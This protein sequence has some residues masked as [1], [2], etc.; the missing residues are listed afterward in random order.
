[1]QG[2]TNT[3]YRYGAYIPFYVLQNMQ[4]D[5]KSLLATLSSVGLRTLL[6]YGFVPGVL[7]SWAFTGAV[8]RLTSFALSSLSTTTEKKELR[9]AKEN[10]RAFISQCLGFAKTNQFAK[11]VLPLKSYVE[12]LKGRMPVVFSTDNTIAVLRRVAAMVSALITFP[13]LVLTNHCIHK[14]QY[15]WEAI[16]SFSL[17]NSSAGL[18]YHL[19]FVAIVSLFSS[20]SE[21]FLRKSFLES[22]KGEA[23]LI[24]KSS[25]IAFW[26][27]KLRM[28]AYPLAVLSTRSQVGK[29]LLWNKEWSLSR[30]IF[31]YTFFVSSAFVL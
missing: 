28:L 31:V 11:W 12:S 27:P 26:L 24:V 21:Y 3:I 10:A 29:S 19:A 22:T 7:Y 16:H 18:A 23:I 4:M 2:I 6:P 14:K 25:L 15:V 13:L 9:E 1:M 17:W 8:E 5:N 20:I 30:G